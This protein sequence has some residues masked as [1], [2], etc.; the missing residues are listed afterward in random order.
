MIEVICFRSKWNKIKTLEHLGKT[1]QYY[2][3]E[4]Q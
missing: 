3:Y 1:D 2:Q 4:R